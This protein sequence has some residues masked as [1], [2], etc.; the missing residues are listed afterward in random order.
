[1]RGLLSKKDSHDFI[2]RHN[3]ERTS[4]FKDTDDPAPDIKLEYLDPATGRPLTR[5]QAFRNMSHIFHGRNPGD[6]KKSKIKRNTMKTRK[7]HA[8]QSTETPLGLVSKAKS[9]FKKMN[10]PFVQLDSNK[11]AALIGLISDFTKLEKLG[12]QKRKK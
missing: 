12:K 4:Y 3:D 9:S 2:G 6:T 5:K 8:K 11:N 1:M 10:K 7:H